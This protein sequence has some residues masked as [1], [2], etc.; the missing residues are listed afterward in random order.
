MKALK[1][2]G[3]WLMA[4][5]DKLIAVSVYLALTASLLYLALRVG[6]IQRMDAEFQRKLD[7]L[8]P[9]YPE[10]AAVSDANY[11]AALA[12]VTNPPQLGDWSSRALTIPELRVWCVECFRPILFRAM[13]CPFCD[14]EQPIPNE[15]NEGLDSDGDGIHDRAEERLGLD[16]NNPS[17]A[18]EDADDDG[19]TNLE[20]YTAGTD[21]RDPASFPSLEPFLTL[22]KIGV[23]PFQFLFKS[24]FKGRGDS[25]TFALNTRD[26]G[27]TYFLRIGDEAEGFK[28]DSFEQKSETSDV[29]YAGARRDLSE[30]TLT[31]GDQKIILIIGKDVKFQD[32]TATILYRRD[33]RR[34]ETKRG[35]KF[36]LRESLEYRVIH[37]D[38]A[39]GSV[40]IRRMSDGVEFSVGSRKVEDGVIEE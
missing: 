25:M 13:T 24:Y 36:A 38:N 4:R 16:P 8:R 27:R 2:I 18:Q 34:F 26:G 21:V 11:L 5:Y 33:G 17:D 29:G 35:D 15:I 39:T 28:L 32:Y 14:V 10:A 22:E 37:I 6:A 9:E 12:A 1:D 19:F 31:K 23:E 20:E 30:L 3:R 40:V 7:G